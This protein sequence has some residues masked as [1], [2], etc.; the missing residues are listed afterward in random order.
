MP[1]SLCQIFALKKSPMIHVVKEK[2]NEFPSILL[3]VFDHQL[4]A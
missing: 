3:D 1:S 4:L 2:V